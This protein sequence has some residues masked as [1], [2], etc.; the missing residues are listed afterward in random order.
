VEVALGL[1]VALIAEELATAARDLWAATARDPF[2]RL[3][4]PPPVLASE[5]TLSFLRRAG[6]RDLERLSLGALFAAADRARATP[7]AE[8]TEAAFVAAAASRAA[9]ATRLGFPDVWSLCLAI[10][11]DGDSAAAAAT[12]TATAT[13]AVAAAVA[14]AAAALRDPRRV[15][16]SFGDSAFITSIE[17]R[18]ADAPEPGR[19]FIVAPGQDVRIRV[20]HRPNASAIGALRVLLHELG[21]AFHT[22]DWRDRLGAP[23]R[24]RDEGTAA[25]YASHL[26]RAD[27][28]ERILGLTPSDATAL[29]ASEVAARARRRARLASDAAAERAFYLSSG[30]PPWQSAL[31]WTDPGASSAYA[32]A[33]PIRD[34][35]DRAEVPRT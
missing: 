23:S 21:H 16:D 34:A 17:V 5:Q 8:R 24:A 1:L 2:A 31:A 3:G 11:G 18:E 19:C 33:E 35:L 30:P 10:A 6:A 27:W 25:W 4:A 12:A 26:E 9:I 7:P 14:A 15:A 20:W 32:A 28:I 29:A 22:L 13:A